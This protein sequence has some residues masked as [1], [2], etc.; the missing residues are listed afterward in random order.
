MATGRTHSRWTRF[1]MNGYDLSGDARSVG[2]LAHTQDVEEMEGLN[3]AVKGAMPSQSMIG[4]GSVNAIL[5]ADGV[6]EMHDLF[7]T[8]SSN[9]PVMIPVG[10]RAEPAAGD[11]VFQA[12]INELAYLLD[13]ATASITVNLNFGNK[14]ASTLLNHSKPWGVLLRAKAAATAANTAVG[15]D[16]NGAAS[17]YGGVMCYQVFAGNGT[18]TITVQDGE[19]N[20]NASFGNLTGATSGAIDCST[21]SAGIIQTATNA[22]VKRYLR[23]QIALGTATTVTFA[24]S[25]VRSAAHNI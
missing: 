13:V 24:L 5:S 2:P 16:D 1:Y 19:A 4:I 11:P 3:W 15:I 14:P 21:P 12:Q 10:I 20:E 22:A 18:A 6:D 8:P 7:A 9:Y 25:F 17:A 23:W